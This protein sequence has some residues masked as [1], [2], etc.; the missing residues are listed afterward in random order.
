MLCEAPPRCAL[1]KI[2]RNLKNEWVAHLMALVVAVNP[3]HF[4]WRPSWSLICGGMSE[5][6]CIPRAAN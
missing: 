5:D 1:S 2:S 6:R 3:S 4:R